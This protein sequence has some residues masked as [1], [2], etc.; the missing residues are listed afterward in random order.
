MYVMLKAQNTTGELNWERLVARILVIV[1]GLFWVFVALGAQKAAYSTSVY[2]LPEFSFGSAIALL[3]LALAVGA[4]V[5]GLYY[6]RLTGLLLLVA[7]LLMLIWGALEHWGDI[8]LWSIAIT[9]LVA[10]A[11]FAGVFY[12]LAARTQEVHEYR[13]STRG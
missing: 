3:P 9:F 6:E 12:L 2:S 5:L 4:F 1:G 7:A 8:G 10:P 11:A 13:A